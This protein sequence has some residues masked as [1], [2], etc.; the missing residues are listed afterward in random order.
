MVVRISGAITGGWFMLLAIC[1]TLLE[2]KAQAEPIEKSTVRATASQRSDNEPVSIVGC[3]SSSCHGSRNSE[4]PVWQQA[5]QIWFDDDP[6][7]KAY[8]QLLTE[9]SKAIVEKLTQRTFSSSDAVEYRSVLSQRCNSCHASAHDNPEQLL[10]GADCQVCHGPLKAWGDSHYS[11]DWHA[12][13]EERFFATKRFNTAS[14]AS[15][16]Q[17]CMSC[18]VGDLN[19]PSVAREVNHDLMAAG[20][21]PM[22][23]EFETFLRA[24]PAHWDRNQD[25]NLFGASVSHKRWQIGQY[26]QAQARLKLLLARVESVD[27]KSEVQ[28]AWPELTEYSCYGCHHSLSEPS[29]RQTRDVLPPFDWDPWSLSGLEYVIPA[30]RVPEFRRSMEALK[31]VI[32]T[33]QPSTDATR[34]AVIPLL[35]F[36][37]KELQICVSESSASPEKIKTDL[38]LLLREQTGRKTWEAGTQWNCA[39]VAHL[40]ALTQ[41]NRQVMKTPTSI[42]KQILSS[43]LDGPVSYHPMQLDSL[44]RDFE[45]LLRKVNP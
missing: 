17:I 44:R 29:W 43:F 45:N 30:D 5:G 39:V 24:Y 23:F 15:R 19:T 33:H 36:I 35:A 12:L 37:E 9:R 41:P 11:S 22:H 42:S 32:Q 31:S 6:H 7:A 38:Q 27:G 21:P 28:R 4:S 25:A 3:L 40:E 20:H 10:M 16:A 14:L 26:S 13:K 18:H 2:N 1:I 8:T 34:I